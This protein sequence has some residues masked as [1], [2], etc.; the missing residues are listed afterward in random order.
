[1]THD[2]ARTLVLL[3]ICLA[4]AT[5][6]GCNRRPAASDPSQPGP[7]AAGRAMPPA[8]ASPKDDGQW[9]MPAKD[10]AN[11]RYSEQ[12]QINRQTVGRL[13]V[14]FTVSVGASGGQESS[15]IVAQN[16]LYFVS[17]Y[18][19]TLFAI[20]LTQ[21]GG[22]VKWRY[23]T[24]PPAAVQGEMCCEPV[25]RGPT[26]SN[27]TV[28]L[29]TPDTR[30]V[31][32]DATTGKLKWETKLGDYTRGDTM[33][34]A[35]FVVG[36]KVIVGNS[37]AEFGARGW[38]AALNVADG[39]IAWRAYSTGPDTDVKIDPKVF[40]P[41]Y[42]QYKGKD[43]GVSQWPTDAWKIGGG[44]VWGW[45]S[46][47]PE[48]DLIFHG[49]S[50]P[51]PWN[52]LQRP[53]DNHWTNG[54]FAREPKTGLAHW[55]Y[56]YSPHDLWDH[57][58]VNENIVLDLPW[59]GRTRKVIIRPERNGYIYV[60]DRTTGEVLAADP[61]IHITA[62]SGVDL[63]TGRLRFNPDMIPQAGKVLRGVCPNS[64]GAKDWSPSA[65][66]KATGLLY[67]P[68]NNLCMDWETKPVN[69]IA[70]TPYIGVTPR[71][72]PGQGGNAGE[73]MAWDPVG[74]RKVW[75]I[76]E[77]WPVWDGA[78]ATAGG[79]VF[80]G[81]LEGWFKAVD[82][83]T[84][85]ELW[86]FKTGSGIIGQPTTFRGPDGRQY[87][88]ILSGVGGWVGSIVTNN[89]DPRDPTAQKGFANMT[90]ELKKIT[91]PGGMLYVFA[92]PKS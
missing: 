82:A 30:T 37:G 75:T 84:G 74:R 36:D 20:D 21:P 40:K 31:A 43:L 57:S 15:P 19:T 70:G 50:N 76:K 26:Y 8:A 5:L 17:H 55:F 79:V 28:Y 9:I 27:G 42:Q 62:S 13:Q 88:A 48:Q 10:F 47:D 16:T 11:T 6:G 59:Q 77:R 23:E 53:G 87:V 85:Q 41:F 56:A 69:Y 7:Q 38:I 39:S 52:H 32:I 2:R 51:A 72:Y 63:K 81:N 65:F 68:H 90:G 35:P 4:V 78:V 49:T 14:D 25:N 1:M 66:S 18:P 46:Y 61:F 22:P 44:T 73:F 92:L 89:L 54:V 33:T 29:N 58:G 3:A 24:R 60:L 83:N 34:M 80:Y 12:T 45:I 91:Q 86:K 67:V 64:P 71:F